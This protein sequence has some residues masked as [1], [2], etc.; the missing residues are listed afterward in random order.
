[1]SRAGSRRDL[2]SK[3]MRHMDDADARRGSCM[4]IILRMESC[5]CDA[6]SYHQPA[7]SLTIGSRCYL[8]GKEN[9]LGISD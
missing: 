2:G 6:L 3:K 1:M 5:R 4:Q 9:Q 8:I 7:S